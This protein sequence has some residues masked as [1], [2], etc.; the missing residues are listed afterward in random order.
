MN[1]LRSAMLAIRL[2]GVAIL[3]LATLATAR[4]D[5]TGGDTFILAPAGAPAGEVGYAQPAPSEAEVG[6][7]PTP[8]Y[9]EPRSQAMRV[10]DVVAY[11]AALAMAAWIILAKRSRRWL[12]ALMAASLLYLGFYRSGCICP[13][14]SIQNVALSLADPS[15][16]ISIVVT[17]IFLLPILAALLV[18]RVFCGG[19]CPFGV[20][21]DLLLRVKIQVPLWID[22]PLRYLRWGYLA[23][24]VY[25]AVGGVGVVLF[26]RWDLAVDPDFI[27]CRFDPFVGL[28]RAIN[29][30]AALAGDFASVFE[31]TGVGWMWIVT[32]GLLAVAMF[33]GRPYCR[34]ICPYGAILGACSRVA[35]RTVTVMPQECCDCELC[36]DACPFGAIEEHASQSHSCVACARCYKSCPLEL[37]RL[38]LPPAEPTYIPPPV[39]TMEPAPAMRGSVAVKRIVG[40]DEE[41]D[42]S[43]VATLVDHFGTGLQAALPLLQQIQTK[44]R[45][46]PRPALEKVCE[47]TGLPM[48]RLLGISTFYNQFRLAP[49]GEHLVC[50][51]HG[52]ACHV[53]GAP[54]ITEA[55]RLQLGLEGDADTDADRKFTVES[56]A[57][58]GCCSL[59]PCMQIDGVTYGHLSGETARKAITNVAEGKVDAAAASPMI[60]PL[61]DAHS[62]HS[63][64]AVGEEEAS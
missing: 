52:T 55:I 37:E 4:D 44:H 58:L 62:A 45:Y 20:V 8:T 31:V 27:I 36:N 23:M 48:A 63:A 32:G 33:V 42:V 26:G 25:F 54:R 34:W 38:G 53:A 7:K 39:E 19:V 28:F 18:G 15:Y 11:A 64:A 29:L 47:L 46:L 5:D 41:I 13:I 12:I 1:R 30:R 61:D 35:K 49:I 57:C 22:K 51:C 40:E 3:C 2:T 14:G 59:A 50:V 24:A 6:T 43:Y 60:G 17:L 16:T 10:V 56:V 9:P 21:Q